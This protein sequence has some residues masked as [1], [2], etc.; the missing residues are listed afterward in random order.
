M[1]DG[2]YVL[3]TANSPDN[4]N[5]SI[6]TAID[7]QA[8]SEHTSF[9]DEVKSYGYGICGGVSRFSSGCKELF[10]EAGEWL[11]GSDYRPGGEG[12]K[13]VRELIEEDRAAIVTLR[14][15]TQIRSLSKFEEPN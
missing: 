2:T 5:I 9:I 8:V 14:S 3:G 6:F 13:T 10:N 15:S 4:N 12:G 1:D 11:L 7:K